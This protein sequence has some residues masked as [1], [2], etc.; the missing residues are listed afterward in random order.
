LSPPTTNSS[1]ASTSA[2]SASPTSK[3]SPLRQPTPNW[4]PPSTQSC[5]RTGR[6]SHGLLERS[7]RQDGAEAARAAAA[8]TYGKQQSA[9]SKLLGY[10]EDYKAGYDEIGDSYKPFAAMGTRLAGN[11]LRRAEQPDRNP[12]SVRTLPSYQFDVA[13]GTD[14][15][16]RS[17]AARGMD[18]SGRTLKDLTRFGTGI[19]DKTYGD[20]LNRLMALN[21]GFTSG[22]EATGAS[23]ALQWRPACSGELGARQ[24]AYGGDM[25]ERR[26]DR[27]GRHRRS[28]RQGGGLAEHHE[29]RHEAGWHGAW[30][31][32]PAL[33]RVRCEWRR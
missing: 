26:H 12:G 14:A 5:K 11:D 20:Q 17:S 31:R 24:T 7:H 29:H 15:V 18:Q 9:I 6:D 10:G 25:S 13:E 21:Q 1:T 19:A 2:S 28:E 22:H 33:G 8:D 16:D 4:R 23:N 3:T 30:R 27:A 32:S